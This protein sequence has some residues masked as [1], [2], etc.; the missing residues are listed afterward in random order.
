MITEKEVRELKSRFMYHA[1]N[2]DQ[3]ERYE[4]IRARVGSLALFISE[5]CPDSR[6]RSVA[7][8]KLD[9]CVMWANASIARNE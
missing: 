5:R 8:T 7:L 4:A 2:G 3:V 9:E 1:P 6:E